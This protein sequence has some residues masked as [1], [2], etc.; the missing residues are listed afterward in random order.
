MAAKQV[1]IAGQLLPTAGVGFAVMVSC[2]LHIWSLSWRARLTMRCLSIQVAVSRVENSRLRELESRMM[3]GDEALENQIHK[4]HTEL[5]HMVRAEFH[6]G[7]RGGDMSR[8]LMSSRY[9]AAE[10]RA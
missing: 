1:K 6:A 2:Y 8:V 3:A 5:E 4:M 7:G 9:R 10:L